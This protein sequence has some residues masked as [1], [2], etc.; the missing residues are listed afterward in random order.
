MNMK[1]WS[2]AALYMELSQNPGDSASRDEDAKH[3]AL[4]CRV[5]ERQYTLR[6]PPHYLTRAMYTYTHTA[7]GRV[8]ELAA[9]VSMASGRTVARVQR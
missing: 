1:H 2:F 6:R 4:C 9:C 7:R 5:A 3:D 8:G